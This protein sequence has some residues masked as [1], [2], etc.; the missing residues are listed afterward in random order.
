MEAGT[1]KNKIDGQDGFPF[2]VK[3][4][5]QKKES[6]KTRWDNPL[7]CNNCNSEI[8]DFVGT[9][10][11]RDVLKTREI[12]FTCDSCKKS[13]NVKLSLLDSIDSERVSWDALFE[14]WDNGNLDVFPAIACEVV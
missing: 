6:N 1:L 7:Y 10:N 4:F 11:L 9:R 8:S 12:S 3:S 13:V 14:L 2:R 5:R